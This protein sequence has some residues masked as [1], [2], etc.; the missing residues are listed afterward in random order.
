MK[1]TRAALG[2]VPV[3]AHAARSMPLLGLG[4]GSAA[5]VGKATLARLRV[6]QTTSAQMRTRAEGVFAAVVLDLDGSGAARAFAVLSALFYNL[7][8]PKTPVGTKNACPAVK[9][10]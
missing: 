5:G 10:S 8:R 4:V 7:A 2:T 3:T 6:E 1:I 9:I